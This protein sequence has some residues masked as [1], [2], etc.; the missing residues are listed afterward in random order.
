MRLFIC[1]QLLLMA[2]NLMPLC[3]LR[4]S[5]PINLLPLSLPPLGVFLVVVIKRVFP[6]ITTLKMEVKQPQLRVT[7]A[8]I[9]AT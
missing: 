8:P 9:V 7:Q 2:I 4:R 6:Q 1:R 5:G 3:L